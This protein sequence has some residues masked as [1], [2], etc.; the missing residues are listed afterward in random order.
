MEKDR[1]TQHEC[2]LKIDLDQPISNEK[3]DGTPN[4]MANIIKITEIHAS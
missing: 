2:I 1:H 3:M 4:K